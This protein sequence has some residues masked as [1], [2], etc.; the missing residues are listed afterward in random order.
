MEASLEPTVD[1]FI[2]PM[3]VASIAA[4]QGWDALM[5]YGYCQQPLSDQKRV[6]SVW[7]TFNDPAIMASMPAAAL[8]FRNGHVSP[9]KK[10][11]C[12]A[13]SRDQ[14]FGPSIRPESCAAART[15]M[16]QS[17]F[18]LG[19]PAVPELD[20]LK[21]TKPPESVHVIHE[22]E[23]SFLSST[24]RRP[25]RPTRARFAAIGTPGVQT[26]DTPKSQVVQGAIGD[27][28]FKLSDVTRA[29]RCA[30]RGRG[31][32]RS[33]R[34]AASLVRPDSDHDGRPRR[35]TET[36]SGPGRLEPGFSVFSEP[37]RGE[38]TVRAPAG[39][40]AVRLLADGR[41][42][43]LA[44]AVYQD[45]RYR[46]PAAEEAEPLVPASQTRKSVRRPV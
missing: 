41:T 35:E 2:A 20:W 39:L 27:R 4:L 26:I 43:A 40:E 45:G 19:I 16:E 24:A 38:V 21:P 7:D 3:Y 22:P 46:I 37:V 1:R 12:L 34:P 23:E 44:D 10:E 28:E 15:L 6:T 42:I 30:A 14:M 33:R 29:G 36:P 17:R 11:Y 18:T 9:A 13:L 5:L 31:R 8:L 32:E 25:S